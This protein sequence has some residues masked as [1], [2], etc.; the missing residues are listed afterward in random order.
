MAFQPIVD[1]EDR[2]VHAYEAL[3]RGVNREG[4]RE[5]LSRV[6]S[7]NRYAFDQSCRIKAIELASSLGILETD[8]HLSI[9]FIPGAMYEPANCVRATLAAARRVG[10]PP[11]RLIFEVTES[12]EVADP[13][14]LAEIFRVYRACGF[15]P[16]IDDFGAG[17]AGLN[18]LARFQPD[19]L[20]IDRELLS[21]IDA[22]RPKRSIVRSVLE[23]CRDLGITPLAEGVETMAEY[24]VLRDMG[25]RLFQGYLFAR[26]EFEALPAP[27][28]PDA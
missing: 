11:D 4:A 2:R 27:V 3:V 5:V 9:N 22:S 19:L 23:V 28:W 17:Y 6:T 21:N 18:L 14:H 8:A 15:H 12:E 10:F 16:A 7:R 25:L 20:K 24:G 26:P 13:E 1:V